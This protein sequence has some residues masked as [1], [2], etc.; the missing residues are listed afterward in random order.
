VFFI[1]FPFFL[2]GFPERNQVKV[3]SSAIRSF[4]IDH[5]I[6]PIAHPANGPPLLRQI[7]TLVKV[8]GAF[9]EPLGFLKTNT[10]RPIPTQAMALILVEFEAHLNS[11]YNCYTIRN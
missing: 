6:K 10:T 11:K 7:R 2:G 4:L 8:V 5:G 9:P 1:E 3:F